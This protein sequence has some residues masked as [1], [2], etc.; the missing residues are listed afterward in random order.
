MIKAAKINRHFTLYNPILYL[1]LFANVNVCALIPAIT[2]FPV[3]LFFKMWKVK[4]RHISNIWDDT[5]YITS[6]LEECSSWVPRHLRTYSVIQPKGHFPLSL[7]QCVTSASNKRGK[8]CAV[9]VR[10]MDEGKWH[11]CLQIRRAS[12]IAQQLCQRLWQQTL[13]WK[14]KELMPRNKLKIVTINWSFSSL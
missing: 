1:M 8:L 4:S 9:W 3:C 6:D 13:L 12:P 14:R 10:R 5:K 11:F 7:T 2:C